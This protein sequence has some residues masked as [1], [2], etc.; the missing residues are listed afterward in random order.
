ML[1][2]YRD[3][4]EDGLTFAFRF[5]D[6]T[7]SIP[8]QGVDLIRQGWSRRGPN[9]LQEGY[10]TAAVLPEQGMY[11]AA[12]VYRPVLQFTDKIAAMLPQKYS[13]LG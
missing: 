4:S 5:T 10:G 12:S 11:L 1:I 9:V 6:A 13:Q 8:N 2:S 7:V 3:G